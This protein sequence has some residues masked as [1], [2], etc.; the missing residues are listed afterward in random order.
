MKRAAQR[1][2]DEGVIHTKV[3]SSGSKNNLRKDCWM[4]GP[5]EEAVAAL[6]IAVRAVAHMRPREGVAIIIRRIS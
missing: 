2:S 5:S 1:D 3:V 4:N 6:G